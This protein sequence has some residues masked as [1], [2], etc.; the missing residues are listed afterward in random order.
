MNKVSESIWYGKN[1]V[2]ALADVQHIEKSFYN[3]DMANGTKKGDLMGI[4]IITKH[5]RWD[6]EADTWANNAY[7]PASDGQAEK[8]MRAW[9]DYRHEFEGG[10]EA[11]KGPQD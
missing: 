2:I 9:C 10:A 4:L 5:T 1:E 8:F 3:C 6:M 11:F 7:I